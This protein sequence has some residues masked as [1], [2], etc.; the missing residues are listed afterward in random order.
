MIDIFRKICIEIYIYI[1]RSY[2]QY[3]TCSYVKHVSAI[4][5]IVGEIF[6]LKL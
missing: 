4:K 3:V 6:K 5:M 2:N 1:I